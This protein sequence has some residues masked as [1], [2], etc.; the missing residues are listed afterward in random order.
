MWE[1]QISRIIVLRPVHLNKTA[2]HEGTGMDCNPNSSYMGGI[3][4][5]AV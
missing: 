5:N 3:E 1:V 4:R 2:R